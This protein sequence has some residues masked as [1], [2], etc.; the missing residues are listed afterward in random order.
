MKKNLLLIMCCISILSMLVSCD[1]EPVTSEIPIMTNTPEGTA[2]LPMTPLYNEITQEKAKE[3]IDTLENYIIVDVRSEMEYDM[4]HIPGA[5]LIWE[6]DIS[7]KASS[8]LPD[9]D[10]VILVYS[11]SSEISKIA[12]WTLGSLGY[13]KV[14][15]FGSITEW[16]YEI[17]R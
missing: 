16:E 5:I 3:M 17:T 4:G 2:E 8:F 1:I 12:A 14:Y 10:A 11:N 7:S 9:K 6:N 15:E 13:M